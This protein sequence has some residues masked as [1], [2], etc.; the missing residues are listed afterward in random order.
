[1]KVGL[2][3]YVL[4]I[5]SSRCI[6]RRWRGGQTSRGISQLRAAGEGASLKTLTQF[7]EVEAS[8]QKSCFLCVSNFKVHQSAQAG[9]FK[10]TDFYFLR[11][12]DRFWEKFFEGEKN[13][14][15]ACA[16]IV[17]FYIFTFVVFFTFLH[18]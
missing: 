1:M 6:E 17:F 7:L 14:E 2:Y 4:Q 3:L 5:L 8:L 15:A 11:N 13:L 18:L 12:M 16:F 10:G 9:V